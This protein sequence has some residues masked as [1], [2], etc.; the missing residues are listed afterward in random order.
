MIEKKIIKIS[1][2]TM[3]VFLGVSLFLMFLGRGNE[4][5]CFEIG[6][7]SFYAAMFFLISINIHSLIIN[8]IQNKIKISLFSIGAYIVSFVLSWMS[9]GVFL[10]VKGNY[11][12]VI[13]DLVYM[14][15]WYI[16]SWFYISIPVYTLV[17]F[18]LYKFRK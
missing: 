14:G 18:I 2:S 7:F 12:D 17:L 5:D 6:F 13:S 10:L 3:L 15:A 9:F 4:L 1:N 11:K 16:P 8:N